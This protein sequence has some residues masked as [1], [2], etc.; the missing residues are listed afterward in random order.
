MG[1]SKKIKVVVLQSGFE[2]AFCSGANIKQFSTDYSDN[3]LDQGIDIFRKVILQFPK[4][5]IAC[6]NKLA[7]GGGFELALA[8]DIIIAE[9]Q[10]KF[11]FPEINLGLFPS[12]GGTLSSKVL[13]KYL[14]SH[15]IFTGEKVTADFLHQQRVVN[16]VYDDYEKCKEEALNLARKIGSF[17]MES[18]ILA[19]KAISFS[20]YEGF[21]KSIDNEK[22]LFDVLLQTEGAKEG[23]QAFIEKRTPNFR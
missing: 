6:V 1:R 13:G 8:C 22:N 4:P 14:T 20:N 9:R 2:K 15:L 16:F 3:L 17:A 10:A 11:G 23:I 19:K 18:L 12:L 5:I 21:Q 7:F